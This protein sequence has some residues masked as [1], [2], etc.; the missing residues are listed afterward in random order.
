M[1]VRLRPPAILERMM[2]MSY[3]RNYKIN[4]IEEIQVDIC[5]NPQQFGFENL[6]LHDAEVLE[7]AALK[8]RLF[9]LKGGKKNGKP[10]NLEN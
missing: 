7:D 9:V 3:W 1:P 8:I 10:S 5:D 4:I 6:S 2:K